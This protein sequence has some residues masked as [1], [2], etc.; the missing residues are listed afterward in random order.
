MGRRSDA[1]GRG[2]PYEA[3]EATNL[4]IQ[5]KV[6]DIA[7][8]MGAWDHCEHT[9]L[10]FP[11]HHRL[12]DRN[13]ALCGLIAAGLNLVLLFWLLLLTRGGFWQTRRFALRLFTPVLTLR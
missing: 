8:L 1:V 3:M 6:H 5:Q 13:P 11:E 7:C 10:L 9:L 2:P 12:S 4:G